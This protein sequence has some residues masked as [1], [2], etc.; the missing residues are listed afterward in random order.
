MEPRRGLATVN[1]WAFSW[2]ADHFLREFFGRDVLRIGDSV[3]PPFSSSCMRPGAS[4]C[5]QASGRGGSKKHV[6]PRNAPKAF[7]CHASYASFAASLHLNSRIG[8][9]GKAD[10]LS[11]GFQSQADYL[12]MDKATSIAGEATNEA[13]CWSMP[14]GIAL[15]YIPLHGP[16]NGRRAWGS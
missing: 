5:F 11:W 2:L 3:S 16:W 4:F 7:L 12:G 8:V 15:P 13:D 6:I 10:T 14:Q 9:P 1:R